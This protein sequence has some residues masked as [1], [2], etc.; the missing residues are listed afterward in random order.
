MVIF[1]SRKMKQRLLNHREDQPGQEL[2]CFEKVSKT[3]KTLL[4]RLIK[5]KGE[6]TNN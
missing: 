5:E 1:Q 6:K 2:V 4:Y 3:D